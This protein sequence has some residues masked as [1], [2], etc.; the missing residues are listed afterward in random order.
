M[1]GVRAFGRSYALVKQEKAKRN[2]Q[3][4]V[5]QPPAQHGCH[6]KDQAHK[7]VLRAATLVVLE[8]IKKGLLK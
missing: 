8:W 1:G 6:L 4:P 7:M 5:A 3:S 2:L